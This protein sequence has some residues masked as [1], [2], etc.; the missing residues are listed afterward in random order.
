MTGNLDTSLVQLHCNSG[1][2]IVALALLINL[3]DLL[4][5]LLLFNLP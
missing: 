3:F 4:E 1:R 2:A 5:E